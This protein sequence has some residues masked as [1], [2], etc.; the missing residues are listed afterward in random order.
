[1]LSIDDASRA[2]ARGTVIKQ[3]QSMSEVSTKTT[4]EMDA[5]IEWWRTPVA[6][7]SQIKVMLAN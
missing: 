6:D 1:M 7:L 4:D 2:R 3:L 5:I